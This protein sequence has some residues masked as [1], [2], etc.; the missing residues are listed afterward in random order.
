MILC[1]FLKHFVG[2]NTAPNLLYCIR[3]IIQSL[4]G[5]VFLKTVKCLI[6]LVSCPK[7]LLPAPRPFKVFIS[8]R[9]N[10]SKIGLEFR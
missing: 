7:R 4:L 8:K 3:F 2:T 9:W 5:H 1:N 10:P 6:N